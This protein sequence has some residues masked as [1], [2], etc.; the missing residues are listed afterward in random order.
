[1]PAS[2]D[3]S[4]SEEDLSLFQSVAVS[5]EDVAAAARR[6]VRALL[7]GCGPQLV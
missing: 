5:A 4:S 2:T 6:E 3:S 7:I 1:M